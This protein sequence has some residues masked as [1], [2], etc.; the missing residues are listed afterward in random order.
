MI[1][2]VHARGFSLSAALSEYSDSKVRLALGIYG[3]K[4]R[5]VDLFL[6]DINGPKGGQ[7]MRCTIKV[8]VQGV[9]SVTV[10]F[11]AEDMYEAINLCARRAKRSIDRRL[12]KNIQ[13]RKVPDH[14]QGALFDE[15]SEQVLVNKQ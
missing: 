6:T 8:H 5:R 3:H 14:R 4:I 7:D 12:S 10:H 15:E 1:V 11:T 2:K 9:P 13:R